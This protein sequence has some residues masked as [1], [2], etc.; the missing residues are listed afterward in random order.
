MIISERDLIKVLAAFCA[1]P[2]L[3]KQV[4]INGFTYVDEG[5][6]N[7]LAVEPLF[8]NGEKVIGVSVCPH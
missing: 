8:K 7:N 1:L 3:F 5:L 4:K 2:L 6:L